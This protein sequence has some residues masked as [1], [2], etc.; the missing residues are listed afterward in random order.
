MQSHMVPPQAGRSD[1]LPEMQ[2]PLLEQAEEW[3]AV[4]GWPYEVSNTGKVRRR[5]TGHVLSGYQDTDGYLRVHLSRGSRASA[6]SR[7]AHRLVL[8]AFVGDRP[9]P[10]H[11]TNH[12]NGIRTDNRLENL[13]WVTPQ[14]NTLHSYRTLGRVPMRGEA[15]HVAILNSEKVLE[16]RRLFAE[17]TRQAEIARMFRVT[18][19]LVFQVVR[20]RTWKHL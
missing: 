3:R 4:V 19:F 2:K 11:I 6:D 8:E 15:V 5:S 18:R 7:F 12:K 9:S 13:E 17:G 14:E 16:I 1:G 10:Q 20:R